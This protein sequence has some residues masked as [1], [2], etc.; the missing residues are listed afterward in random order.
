[1]LYVDFTSIVFRFS[2]KIKLDLVK[3]KDGPASD[4]KIFGP[5]PGPEKKNIQTRARARTRSNPGSDPSLDMPAAHYKQSTVDRLNSMD[6]K[7]IEKRRKEDN[8]QTAIV[9]F[10]LRMLKN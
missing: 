3:T 2:A 5:G 8:D 9:I 4:K 1:V 10:C 7:R 6:D